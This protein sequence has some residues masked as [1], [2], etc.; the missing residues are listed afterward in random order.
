MQSGYGEK[1]YKLRRPTYGTD[2][3]LCR[4]LTHPLA[5]VADAL[6]AFDSAWEGTSSGTR[7]C[8]TVTINYGSGSDFRQF[9]DG[10]GS[11]SYALPFKCK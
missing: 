4:Y 11:G 10:S 3:M 7:C 6:E 2:L 1:R 5:S 9:V 8:G